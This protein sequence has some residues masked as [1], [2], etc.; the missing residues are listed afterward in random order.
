MRIL[1]YLAEL[2][3]KNLFDNP[4]ALNYL[5]LRGIK[6]STIQYFKIGYCCN[7]I[8]YQSVLSE[9][10]TPLEIVDALMFK[11]EK[12]IDIFN[13]RIVYPIV[14]QGDVVTFTSRFVGNN[15]GRFKTP[16]LH[17]KGKFEVAYNHDIIK[18][19]QII[20]ITEGV[21]DCLT[22]YQ[23]RLS[24][25]ALFG[26]THISRN[27][28]SSLIGKQIY[29]VFDNDLNGSGQKGA[30]KIASLLCAYGTNCKIVTLK[31][32]LG[33]KTDVNAY[34]MK[35]ERKDFIECVKNAQEFTLNDI[36][37]HNIKYRKH[38]TISNL[39]DIIK[40]VSQYINVLFTGGKPR[41]ICPFH[42]DQFPSLV[43]Y[44]ENRSWYCFGC[45]K[46]GNSYTFIREIEKLRGNKLTKLE[47]GKI[48]KTLL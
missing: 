22:L 45:G 12:G 8:G 21:S 32:T 44:E 39:P 34:F 9:N 3:H 19:N 17:R 37:K 10:F 40:T 14:Y 27:I 6:K 43:L 30:K 13:N 15:W 46:G 24:S 2:Y 26:C 48:A 11:T 38:E 35:Y 23:N 31:P 20:Y 1:N 4:H 33:D 29:I 36:E 28:I 7:D 47:V 5:F 16:H 42:A 41:A 18:E 25:I